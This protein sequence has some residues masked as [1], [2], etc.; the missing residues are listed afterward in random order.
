MLTTSKASGQH[1][2]CALKSI[3]YIL[4]LNSIVYLTKTYNENKWLKEIKKK[5]SEIWHE[6]VMKDF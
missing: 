5:F 1:L 6:G 4:F 3:N 2:I